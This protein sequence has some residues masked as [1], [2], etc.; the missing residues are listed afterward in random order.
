M[1]DEDIQV[2]VARLEERQ[3]AFDRLVHVKFD[4][5][6]EA[7]RLQAFEIERRLGVLNHENERILEASMRSVSIDKYDANRD[8][9]LQRLSILEEWKSGITGGRSSQANQRLWLGVAVALV[10]AFIAIANY[11]SASITSP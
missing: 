11:V 8:S 5:L 3:A 1:A 6:S 9:D 7:L 2:K 4:A 10:V